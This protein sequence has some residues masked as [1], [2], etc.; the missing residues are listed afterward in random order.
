[1]KHAGFVEVPELSHVLD[2]VELDGVARLNLSGLDLL[3]LIMCEYNKF[4]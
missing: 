2:T 1:M 3:L 4:E